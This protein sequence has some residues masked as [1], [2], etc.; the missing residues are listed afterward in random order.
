[1][2]LLVTRQVV[3]SRAN[4]RHHCNSKAK[5]LRDLRIPRRRIYKIAM[6]KASKNALTTTTSLTERRSDADQGSPDLG[7]RNTLD[8]R[9]EA[10]VRYSVQDSEPRKTPDRRLVTDPFTETTWLFL[11]TARR[12]GEAELRPNRGRLGP[13]I[14]SLLT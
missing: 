5:G 11:L 7:L 14:S 10:T 3:P 12:I 9:D 4:R 6:G 1:M 2:L 8:P 13:A